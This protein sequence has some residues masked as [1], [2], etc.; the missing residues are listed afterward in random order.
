MVGEGRDRYVIGLVN[1]GIGGIKCGE[2][3]GYQ[4]YT[5]IKPY[6]PWV[7]EE[8]ERFLDE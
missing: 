7:N 8:I 3:G 6:I 1:H 2:K 4:Y 5:Y